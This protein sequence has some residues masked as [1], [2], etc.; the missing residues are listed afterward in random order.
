MDEAAAVAFANLLAQLIPMGIGV[1]NQIASANTEA[2]LKPIADI[3]AAAD[4]NYAAIDAAAQAEIAKT[5][6]A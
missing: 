1:Y 3:L 5:P 4:A 6:A 2:G